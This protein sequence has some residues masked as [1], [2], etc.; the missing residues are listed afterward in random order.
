VI[1]SIAWFHPL[2]RLVSLHSCADVLRVESRKAR[3]R[4]SAESFLRTIQKGWDLNLTGALQEKERIP[5]FSA[6]RVGILSAAYKSPR[7]A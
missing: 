5:G 7:A 4:V 3:Q 1:Y 6:E 2:D